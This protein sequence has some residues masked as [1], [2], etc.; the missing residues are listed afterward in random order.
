MEINQLNINSFIME[1][2]RI[3]ILKYTIQ[4][5]TFPDIS[6]PEVKQPNPFQAI[7]QVGDHIIHE[8]LSFTFLVDEQMNNYRALYYWIRGLAFP[9][10]FEE[11]DLFIRGIIGNDNIQTFTSSSR[12]NQFSDVLIT[13]LSNHKN[14]LFK[15]RLL[16]A[17]P[18][19]LSGFSASVTDSDTQ[20]ITAT[21]TMKFTGFEIEPA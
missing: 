10:R 20:P 12:L 16:D 13:V 21:C 1:V 7:N 11:F 3:P 14:P 4:E 2:V 17:F 8:D 9:E 5:V 18:V 19:S 6:L 15:Y